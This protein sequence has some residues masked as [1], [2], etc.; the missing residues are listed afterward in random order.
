[1][2]IKGFVNGILGRLGYEV[3]SKQFVGSM[4]G[5]LEHVEQRGMRC[6]AILDVGANTATWSREARK[7]FPDA[8]IYMV[9]PQVAMEEYL[10]A[11]CNEH[12]NARYWLAG[13]GA[14]SGTLDL[15]IWGTNGDG[16]SF[17]PEMMGPEE[18]VLPSVSV[19]VLTIDSLLDDGMPMPQL[20]KLDV[21]G[22]EL[23]VLKGASKLWGN[24]EVFI[25]DVPVAFRN[26]HTA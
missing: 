25:L 1:M 9:E 13:A 10:R 21:E 12:G 11:F 17:W 26:S 7:V 24:T 18:Q 14:E 5:F 2:T 6:T 22:F 23:E 16:S 8:G 20:V 4:A 19:P 15:A 3:R